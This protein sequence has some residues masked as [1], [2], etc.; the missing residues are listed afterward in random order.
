MGWVDIVFI[1]LIALF[2]IIGLSK[3]L[4]ESLLGIFSSVLSVA[5]AISV[6]GP[7]TDFINKTVN[8]N[9]F[10]GETLKS[11]GWITENGATIFGKVYS[12]EQ[13]GNAV[14]VIVAIVAV[15][16]LIKLAIWLLAKLFDSATSSSSALSGLNR[17]LG[18]I[19]GAAKG[20]II[21]V[22]ILGLASL[23]SI[24]GVANIKTTIENESKFTNFV[25]GYVNEW[26]A[27][28]VE[29]RVDDVLGKGTLEGQEPVTVT[30]EDGTQV[31]VL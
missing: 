22:V 27:K 25:Y 30:F 16:L 1:V 24:C 20:F 7:V 29:D 18:L 4:F 10:F 19:F 23:L 11:W 9:V 13:I 26:V 15:W 6:S 28:T 17:V 2:A 14:S 3:G 21:G 31:D 5:I 8:A 12:V